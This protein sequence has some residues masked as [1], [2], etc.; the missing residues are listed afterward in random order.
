MRFRRRIKIFPGFHLNFSNSG[1]SSTIGIRGA[2]I[3]FSKRG[4]YL[5]TSIPGTG[6]YDRQKI[7][8]KKAPASPDQGAPLNS[9]VIPEEVEAPNH[10][11]KRVEADKLTSASFS[12]LKESIIEAY[13]DR[14]ELTAEI[15]KTV[16]QLN[17]AKTIYVITCI[18]IVGFIFKAIKNRV[19]D[20]E[21]YLADLHN[22]LEKSVINLEM[23]F[24]ENVRSQYTTMVACYKELLTSH[25]IWDI[26]A[27]YEQ[28]R[29]VTR[30]AASTS[31]LR[32]PV[33][34]KFDSVDIIKSTVSAFHFEN[35]NGG[36]LLI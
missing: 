29:K 22:Q 17:S 16:K 11:I 8:G 1:I 24:D 33:N 2:S 36:D 9:P 15:R 5:N 34:F 7:R 14:K 3:T 21:D 35:K 10:E 30:S 4:T 6:L 28:D 27:S 13:N 23:E 12:E 19:Y 31:V 32:T 18:L 20:L 25:I 26:T